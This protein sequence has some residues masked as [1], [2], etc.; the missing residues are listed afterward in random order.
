MSTH[1]HG[2]QLPDPPAWDGDA[3]FDIVS[4]ICRQAIDDYLRGY[5]SRKH[6]DA[7]TFLRQVGLLC[8]DGSID[9]H[10]YAMPAIKVRRR[11]KKNEAL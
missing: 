11:P 3:P 10:G 5:K 6:P 1:P 9:P 2:P 8:D 4:A 7:A